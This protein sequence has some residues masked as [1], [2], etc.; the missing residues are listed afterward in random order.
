[1]WN[2]T[3]Y[4]GYPITFYTEEEYKVLE[5]KLAV[6]KKIMYNLFEACDDESIELKDYFKGVLKSMD[7]LDE[8]IE[9][10]AKEDVV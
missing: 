2:T 7:L 9:K 10:R 8:F 6:Y 3:D 1:M 5:E 4:R